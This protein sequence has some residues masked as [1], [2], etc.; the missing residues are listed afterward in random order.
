[1]PMTD[2]PPDQIPEVTD[3]VT[4]EVLLQKIVEY[5]NLAIRA[6]ADY[7]NLQRE[8]DQK[9][10]DMR[11]FAN[12]QLLFELFPLV[13]YF[14]SALAAIPEDQKEQSWIQGIKHIQDYLMK[15]LQD[16]AV[17]RMN[18]L[19]QPFNPNIHEAVGQEESDQPEHTIIKEVQAGFTLH[20]KMIRPAKVIISKNKLT[21][22]NPNQSNI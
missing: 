17:E 6:T 7:R 9:I 22:N 3:A 2:K 16:Q 10:Q 5:K 8:T 20:G 15:V 1:M 19:S 11:K 4:E 14:D 12:D 13:D 18:T 21:N